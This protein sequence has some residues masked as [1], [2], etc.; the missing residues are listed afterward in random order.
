M[1]AQFN[2][3]DIIGNSAGSGGNFHHVATRHI[4]ELR[5]F[6]DEARDQ[7]GTGDAVDLGALTGDP[8][9][10]ISLAG[11]NLPQKK[12]LNRRGRGGIHG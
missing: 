12:L 7:P 9:H 11:R 6:V 3:G 8:L 2:T 1:M 10:G 4:Q 5:R